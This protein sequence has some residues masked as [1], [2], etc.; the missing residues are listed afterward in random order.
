[1]VTKTARYNRPRY[2]RP[3]AVIAIFDNFFGKMY[4]QMF[5]IF[6]GMRCFPKNTIILQNMYLVHEWEFAYFHKIHF[7]PKFTQRAFQSIFAHNKNVFS[8]MYVIFRVDIECEKIHLLC[9]KYLS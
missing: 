7:S 8:R 3:P 9:W 5:S 4:A 6:V 2:N 1:M